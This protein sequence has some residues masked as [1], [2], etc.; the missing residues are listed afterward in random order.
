MWWLAHYAGLAA[1]LQ[2]RGREI[3]R[4]DDCAIFALS[5]SATATGAGA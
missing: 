1:H 4:D 2:Q 5:D 3:Y